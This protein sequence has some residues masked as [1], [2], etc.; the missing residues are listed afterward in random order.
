MQATLRPG[1]LDWLMERR[2]TIEPQ[3]RTLGSELSL[4]LGCGP[5]PRNPF[6]ATQLKGIDRR[7]NADGSILGADLALEPIPFDN[8]SIDYVTAYDFIEHVPRIIYAP[9][10]RYAFVELMNEVHRVLRPGG[11]FLSFT[12]AIPHGEAFRD[13]THVNFITDETFPLYFCGVAPWARMYGFEGTFDCIGQEWHGP[14]L[15]SL[16][17]RLEVRP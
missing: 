12:P 5:Q 11:I 2:R 14:H 4:D 16:L 3:A 8:C 6:G 9:E 7:G 17:R 1:V 10:A 13:P 15:L